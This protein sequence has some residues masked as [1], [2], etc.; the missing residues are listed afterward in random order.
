M[1]MRPLNHSEIREMIARDEAIIAHQPRCPKCATDQVQIKFKGI[2]ARWKCRRC[3]HWFTSEPLSSRRPQAAGGDV[4]PAVYSMDQVAERLHKSRRW[5]QDFLRGRDIGRL[6]GRT[7]LF[8]DADILRLIEAVAMPLKLIPPRKSPN[9]SIRGT[10]LGRYIDRSSGSGKRAVAAKVLK[11][12]ERQIERGAYAEPG[13][14]TF[15]SA[16]ASYMKAGGERKYL[17]KLLEHFGD[18]PLREI[19]QAEIDAAQLHLYPIRHSGD[20]KSQRLHSGFGC[21]APRW[22]TTS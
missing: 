10:Y 8:T 21:Y 14:A 18:K 13:E 22:P 9:W 4:S 7:K 3:K 5:L 6:A 20:S 1:S 12:I 2:P 16:A 17:R 15:A 19:D 11:G